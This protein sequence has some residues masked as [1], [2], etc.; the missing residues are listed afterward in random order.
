MTTNTTENREV[1]SITIAFPVVSDEDSMK[2][3]ADVKEA[4]K[5]HPDARIDFRIMNMG[6]KR[7]GL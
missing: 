3:K 2:V 6:S 1:C 5:D 4:L 7:V